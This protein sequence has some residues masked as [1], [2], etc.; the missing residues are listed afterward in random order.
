MKSTVVEYAAGA[1]PEQEEIAVRAIAVKEFRELRRDRRTLAMLFLLPFLFLVV[2]GYAASFDIKDV[3]TVVVGAGAQ[4]VAGVLP[5]PFDVVATDGGG[6]AAARDEL[7]RGNAVVAVVTPA[8]GGG[9]ATVLI[10]GTELFAAQAALRSLA[11]LKASGASGAAGGGQ[12]PLG[13]ASTPSVQVSVLFNPELRT[14]VIMI[15]GLCGIILVFV[16]TIATALGVVRER[17]SGTMEQLAVMPFRP[18]DV[19][20]GK[21]APYLLIAAADMVIV[22]VAGMLLFDVPFRGSVA[23]FALG[24]LLFLFVTLGTG[25]LISSVSQTQAQAMQLSVMTMVPQFLLSGLFFPLYSMPW[26][27]RWIGYLLPLTWFIKVARGVM[28][29]GAPIGALWLP[30]VILAVMAVVVFTASTLRFRRDL[31]PA[32]GPEG[33]DQVER[34]EPASDTLETAT[35]ATS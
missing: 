11:E 20:L 17:Q 30:L 14:A 13:G 31:A 24:A 29:R 15:P 27:V 26:A 23:T 3:P 7:Q 6:D 22:V 1:N 12:S 18:R 28:V 25:V 9:K 32:G 8:A 19:F 34:P 16:G 2:F 10:D 35:G 21:I 33:T 4:T 5:A